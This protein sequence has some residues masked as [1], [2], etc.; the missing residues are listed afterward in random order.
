MQ[1]ATRSIEFLEGTLNIPVNSPSL[2][3]L[4]LT[5]IVFYEKFLGKGLEY[6]YT[7]EDL[8]IRLDEDLRTQI[9]GILKIYRSKPHVTMD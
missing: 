1:I 9:I 8:S 3:F 7:M 5:N 4:V 2:L 6:L